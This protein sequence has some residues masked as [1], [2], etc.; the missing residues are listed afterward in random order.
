LWIGISCLCTESEKQICLVSFRLRCEHAGGGPRRF[1]ARRTSIEQNNA[2]LAP[3]VQ[4]ARNT[5]ADDTGSDYQGLR[6]HQ[7]RY[8]FLSALRCTF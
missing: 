8:L 1:A 6:S 7:Q 3:T 4:L 2:A 5:Q